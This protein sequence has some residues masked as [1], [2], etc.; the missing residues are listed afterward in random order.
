MTKNITSASLLKQIR[1]IAALRCYD[2]VF[3]S[4]SMKQDL[5]MKKMYAAY[6][7]DVDANTTSQT[8]LL[9]AGHGPYAD[10]F[11]KEF[12]VV[13]DNNL[14]SEY[15]NCKLVLKKYFF[16]ENEFERIV[17]HEHFD[18]DSLS[19]PTKASNGTRASGRYLRDLSQHALRNIK[20]AVIIAEEWLKS[21][22]APPSGRVWDDLYAHVL[23][24]WEDINKTEKIFVGFMS[25]VIFSKYNEGGVNHL[26]CLV[27]DDESVGTT[28]R[29]DTRKR[30]KPGDLRERDKPVKNKE[31]SISAAGSVQS[32]DNLRGMS[33][34]N[35]IQIMELAQLSD[36]KVREDFKTTLV[37]MQQKQDFLIRERGQAIDMA[38]IICAVYNRDDPAWQSVFE[39]TKDINQIK[40]RID[41]VEKKRQETLTAKSANSQMVDNFLNSMRT[42]KKRS[43]EHITDASNEHV[44]GSPSSVQGASIARDG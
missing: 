35:K 19:S 10:L 38:K 13:T 2:F 24:R 18:L 7:G 40:K 14:S 32:P 30:D 39:L 23:S 1:A 4:G 8:K 15:S 37:N 34:H 21:N 44:V 29:S 5:Q 41:T 28:F 36:Q 22:E 3:E 43:F 42:N 33:L 9:L 11:D 26:A 16:P 6:H 27:M 31:S 17:A 20:K 12:V 25:F